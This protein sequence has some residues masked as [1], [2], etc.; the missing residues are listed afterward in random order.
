MLQSATTATTTINSLATTDPDPLGLRSVS[1]FCISVSIGRLGARFRL[2]FV[3]IWCWNS[4]GGYWGGRWGRS[5]TGVWSE[6]EGQWGLFWAAIDS[7]IGCI[8]RVLDWI[9]CGIE[10]WGFIDWFFRKRV[11]HGVRSG[12]FRVRGFLVNGN[13]L[14][15]FT[16]PFQ[17]VEIVFSLFFSLL[18]YS[19]DA[20]M[21]FTLNEI[22][23]FWKLKKSRNYNVECMREL[24]SIKVF[25]IRI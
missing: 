16:S 18:Y 12:R 19:Q 2:G 24:S 14:D 4:S 6:S 9:W 13:R 25:W 11:V 23:A 1:E 17:K 21:L 8:L 5:E 7:G 3:K 15:L 20:L 22:V 10:M